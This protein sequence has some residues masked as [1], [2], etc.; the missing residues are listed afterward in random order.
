[1]TVGELKKSLDSAKDEDEVNVYVS[2]DATLSVSGKGHR[3][4]GYIVKDVE[5]IATKCAEGMVVLIT[6]PTTNKVL[7]LSNKLVTP[8]DSLHMVTIDT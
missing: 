6:S 5:H 2:Y 7:V 1:M 3:E 4:K 8:Q